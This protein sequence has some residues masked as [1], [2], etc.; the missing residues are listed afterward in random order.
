MDSG[1][2]QEPVGR[3]GVRFTVTPASVPR[4]RAVPAGLAILFAV[5][6]MASTPPQPDVFQMVIRL[7]VAT[8][9]GWWVHAWT[10]RWIAGRVDRARSP[11]GTFV[12]SPSGIEANGGRITREQ[13]RLI[14]RNGIRKGAAPAAASTVLADLG[15]RRRGGDPPSAASVCYMLC[16]ESDSTSTTL[17]G[18][19]TEVTAHGLLTDV[20]RILSSSG[21]PRAASETFH[22]Q[23][24]IEA[25]NLDR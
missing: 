21:R 12:V 23:A 22:D 8:Y 18:G 6:V 1:Y 11:G 9:G 4:A 14:V 3:G 19:M 15:T 10:R 13:L 7:T 25:P 17:A 24:V 2:Q 16:A 20:S 5:I